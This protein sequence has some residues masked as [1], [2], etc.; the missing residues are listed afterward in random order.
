MF[1]ILIMDHDMENIWQKHLENLDSHY[2]PENFFAL[3]TD[4]PNN[5]PNI[6]EIFSPTPF[7]DEEDT[8][9]EGQLNID[10]LQDDNNL[11]LITP[12]AGV[13]PE[14]IE[15]ILEKDVI[16]IKGERKNIFI[17]SNKQ[18]LFKECYWGQFSR[19]II[20]PVSV[21]EKN[22]QAEFNKGI[23]QITLPKAPESKKISIKIKN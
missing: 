8:I 23:L 12:I 4:K 20:L 3:Q 18:T 16:T 13:E 10:I 19:S 15:I 7:I 6:K 14:K 11:Y 1:F 5:K 2:D 21:D 9:E 17:N 22:L